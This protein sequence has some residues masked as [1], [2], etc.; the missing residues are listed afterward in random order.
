MPKNTLK[1]WKNL[2]REKLSNTNC[3]RTLRF[4]IFGLGDSSYLQ[5]VLIHLI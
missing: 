1:F 4:A 2:R 5:Y 3:L